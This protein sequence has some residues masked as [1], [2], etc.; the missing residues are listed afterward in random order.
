MTKKITT[1]QLLYRDDNDIIIIK[2]LFII[3]TSEEIIL[4]GKE[5]DFITLTI[6]SMNAFINFDYKNLLSGNS[7]S[8]STV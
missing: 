6:Y 1:I 4:L 2:S 5:I 3:I 7:R 8:L